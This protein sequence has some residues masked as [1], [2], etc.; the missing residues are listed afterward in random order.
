MWNMFDDENDDPTIPSCAPHKQKEIRVRIVVDNKEYSL[1]NMIQYPPRGMG[2]RGP[3]HLTRLMIN[4]L[5]RQMK[6]EGI[7]KK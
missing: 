3:I 4:D 6:A 2:G 1:H 5:I 7:F